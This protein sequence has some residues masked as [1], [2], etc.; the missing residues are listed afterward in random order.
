MTRRDLLLIR[1]LWV[2]AAIALAACWRVEA[3]VILIPLAVLGPALREV[4]PAR[5]QDERERLE[6]YRASHV[7]FMATYGLLFLLSARSWLQL[8]QS[9]PNELWLLVVAPLLVRVTLAVGRGA[10]ARRLALLLGFVSGAAWAAFS[11]LSHGLSVETAIGGSLILFTAL[12]VRRPR[13]GGGLLTLT[14]LLLLVIF[15]VLPLGRQDWIGSLL[16]MLALPLPPLLAGIGLVAWSFR[17]RR[18]PADEFGD[19]RARA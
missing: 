18:T 14:G 12:G 5:D 17:D 6:D 10:G 11:V 19:L 2:A 16:M 7:A 8:G 1:L 15:I 13:L 3:L 9:P 4:V